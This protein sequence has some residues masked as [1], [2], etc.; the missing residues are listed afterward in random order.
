[1][2]NAQSL[3]GIEKIPTDAH[4]RNLMDE[5]QPSNVFPVFDYIIERLK[6][7]GFSGC[8]PVL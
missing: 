4:I 6:T 2:N 3:F 8:F 1:M 7:M 5:V